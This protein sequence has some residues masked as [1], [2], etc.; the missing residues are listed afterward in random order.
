[1]TI[2]EL[3]S[4]G[5]LL[6]EYKRGSHLYHLNTPTSDEDYGGVYLCGVGELLG[7]RSNYTEQ[8]SDERHD[9][10]YYELGR[11]VELL[12]KSNPTAL[13]SLFVP[14][15]C[16][17]GEVHPIVQR[18]IDNR[19]MFVSKDCFQSFYG[20][21][22]SQIR[23]ARGLNKKIVQP[24]VVR[25]GILDFCNTFYKQGSA[26]IANW[27]SKRGLDQRY[28]GLVNIPNMYDCYGV[29]Y[30][31]GFH[32]KDKGIGED[33]FET[34]YVNGDPTVAFIAAHYHI[35]HWNWDSFL[36]WFRSQKPIGYRGIVATEGGE[37][38]SVRLSSVEKGELPICYLNYNKDGFVSH[39]K[40]YKEYQE[41]VQK[42]NKVRYESNLNKNYDAKNM[43]HCMRLIRMS[44]ELAQGK[45]FNLVR[46]GD[47]DILLDIRNHKFE[48]D[49]IISMLEKEQAEMEDAIKTCTIREHVDEEAVNELLVSVR[50]E[51][52]GI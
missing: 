49:E 45:G 37:S 23:K 52:Y 7:L 8:V 22:V 14:E 10:T 40:K 20:Y 29:Y 50:K 33:E 30:D 26:S 48:Y 24:I 43:M 11:W 39:C 18:F 16:I 28:C 3:K 9:E 4:R 41:W 32:F 27:L 2:E 19:D 46:D 6:Y 35:N 42:R 17:V 51:A 21:A 36:G 13:E 38:T 47:R 12:L 44:K 15:D 25:K 34:M 31:W 5:M 1:M